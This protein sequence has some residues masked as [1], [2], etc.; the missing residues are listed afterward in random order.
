[1][2]V[3]DDQS[4]M[5]G[6]V[7]NQTR[8][9]ANDADEEEEAEIQ[10]D[11]QQEDDNRYES[12]GISHLQLNKLISFMP[13][14]LSMSGEEIGEITTG[15]VSRLAS[16][17]QKCENV[18]DT[19]I[20]KTMQ[21]LIPEI[22][23]HSQCIDDYANEIVDKCT[24]SNSFTSFT[25]FRHAIVGPSKSG[26][27]TFLRILA[28]ATLNRMFASGQYR[29][30]MFVQM[31]MREMVANLSDPIK[32]YKEIVR[33]TFKHLAAQK[34]D[35]APF[36]ECLCAYFEKLPSLE[37]LVPLPNKFTVEE[38]FRNAVPILTEVAT[39]LWQC[40][41]T[42]HSLAPWMTNVMMI[43][44]FM[45]QAFGFGNIHFVIDHIDASDIEITASEPFDNDKTVITVIEFIKFMLSNDS[46]VV[47]CEKD[48]NLLQSLDLATCDGVD[49]RDC[50]Q[51]ISVV[52]VDTEHLSKFWFN[53][54]VQGEI[55]PIKLRDIDCGG[56]SGYL[57]LWDNLMVLGD[58]LWNEQMKDKN[59]KSAKELKLVLLGKIRQ[60]APK[61]LVKIDEESL[62][63]VPIGQIKDFELI[64]LECNEEE[65]EEEEEHHE[66]ETNE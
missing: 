22:P 10:F 21:G 32:L 13:G 33:I 30:T 11:E 15:I 38:D 39:N 20:Y 37:K 23:P 53:L 35:L 54:T 2:I 40:I 4:G 18:Q 58:R 47:S 36:C 26:K 57:S 8:R 65:E 3:V 48:E 42:F 5:A 60:L 31:D 41:N 24:F 59:S 19:I 29:K 28:S 25:K 50:T 51:I 52:D 64:N 7:M 49:L 44:R 16:S 9:R 1:M 66:E 43:P 45:A 63:P 14:N 61:V 34:V 12:T 46:F 62:C 55:K 56:C 27:S 17:A 6:T